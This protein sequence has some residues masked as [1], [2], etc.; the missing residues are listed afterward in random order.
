MSDDDLEMP[1]A[2]RGPAYPFI[3]LPRVMER[4]E[5]YH[6]AGLTRM[7]VN[8]VSFY[9]S[10]GYNKESGNARQTLA[11]LNHFGLVEYIGRGTDRK[12]KLSKLALRILLDKVPGSQ[13]RVAAIKE[14]ALN[15]PIYRDLWDQ[16]EHSLVPDHAMETFLTLEKGFSEESAKKVISGYRDTFSYANLGDS[17]TLTEVGPDNLPEIEA[18]P[19]TFNQPVGVKAPP[20]AESRMQQAISPMPISG[21]PLPLA[22]TNEIK[23]MLDGPFI[24]VSAVVDARSAKKLMKALKANIALLEDDDDQDDDGDAETN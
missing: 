3:P 16:F 21:G 14:A 2:T 11:A 13:A 7:E 5:Q 22:S 1:S 4:V 19:A 24:R 10:W 23:V 9:K 6:G 18:D 20:L 12:A 8:P 15:P 17:D